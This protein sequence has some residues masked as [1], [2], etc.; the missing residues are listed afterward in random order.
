MRKGQIVMVIGYSDRL[1]DVEPVF[2]PG[3]LAV[4]KD[5]HGEGDLSC[6]AVTFDGRI[7]PHRSDMLWPEEVLVV[8]N[9]PLVVLGGQC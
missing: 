9:T 4:V 6:C 1:D 2:I 7:A 3:D 5:V 8:N